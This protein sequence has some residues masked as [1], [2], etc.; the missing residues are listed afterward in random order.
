MLC[1]SSSKQV[2]GLVDEKTPN[3][4]SLT[5]WIRILKPGLR[6]FCGSTLAFSQ[7]GC[8]VESG[9]LFLG[10]RFLQEQGNNNKVVHPISG[11]SVVLT[12]G[13][14][15]A[16]EVFFA[17]FFVSHWGCHRDLNG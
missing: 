12:F 5:V 14:D 17:K 9:L 4:L 8:R 2:F 1:F 11:V 6:L 13:C 7:V 10:G 16:R 3:R 15:P